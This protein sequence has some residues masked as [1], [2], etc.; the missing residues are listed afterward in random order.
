[1]SNLETAKHHC[2]GQLP[3]VTLQAINYKLKILDSNG[4]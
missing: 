2:P 1:M 4:N 3:D